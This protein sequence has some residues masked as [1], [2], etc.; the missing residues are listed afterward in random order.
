MKYLLIF[1]TVLLMGC[2]QKM[3]EPTV[4]TVTKVVIQK[5]SIPS[6]LLSIPPLP[7]VPKNISLQSQVA[8]YIIDLYNV[9]S[10]YK[11]NLNSIKEWNANGK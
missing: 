1:L 3:P 5:Q 2:S 10:Q 11:Q 7:R 4:R 9:A 8:K 6:G